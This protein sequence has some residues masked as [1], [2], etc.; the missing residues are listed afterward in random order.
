[1]PLPRWFLFPEGMI[2][3]PPHDGLVVARA[4]DDQRHS[5]DRPPKV[6]IIL[7][8]LVSILILLTPFVLGTRGIGRFFYH[9]TMRDSP[10]RA[11]CLTPEALNL[12]PLTKFRG[13]ADGPKSG[14]GGTGYSP[15]QPDNLNSCSICTEDFGRGVEFRPLPCGHRFHPACIDPWLL[16]RSLTCPLWS[17]SQEKPSY[18][19]SPHIVASTSLPASSLAP[20]PKRPHS[21]AGFSS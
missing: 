6:A 20:V 2:L 5:P 8:I 16:Q 17:V 1:M 11:L 9:R 15:E 7:A 3:V 13:K 14:G 18:K 21:L 10:E 19:D 12:M 4:V